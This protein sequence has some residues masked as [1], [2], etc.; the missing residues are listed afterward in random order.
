[1]NMVGMIYM[2]IVFSCIVQNRAV[3]I[4]A[5][6]QMQLTH[7]FLKPKKGGTGIEIKDSVFICIVQNHV[8]FHIVVSQMSKKLLFINNR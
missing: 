2:E 6:I 7:Q 5:K 3:G 8:I 1:M 4:P